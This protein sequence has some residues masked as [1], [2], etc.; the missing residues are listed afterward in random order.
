[1]RIRLEEGLPMVSCSI[2]IAGKTIELTQ[3][4]LDTGSGGT[5]VSADRLLE[6]GVEADPT[7]RIVSIRGVGGVEFV[8]RK[9]ASEVRL[10][11]L[12]V[13]NVPIQI[14]SMNYGFALDA[15]VGTDVLHAMEAIIDLGTLQLRGPATDRP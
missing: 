13:R 3:A 7:D 2:L 5:L 15:I 4:L 8:L 11:D 9:E 10:G 6:A 1:M 12:T 14:G